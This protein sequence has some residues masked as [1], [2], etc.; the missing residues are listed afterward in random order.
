MMERTDVALLGA[1][2]LADLVASPPDDARSCIVRITS[3]TSDRGP[4]VVATEYD[5]GAPYRLSGDEQV[6]RMV[7]CIGSLSARLA[8]VLIARSGPDNQ[9]RHILPLDP[10]DLNPELETLFSDYSPQGF[11]GF[12]SFVLNATQFI[13]ASTAIHVVVVKLT[14]ELLSKDR[15]ELLRKRL[16]NARQTEIYIAAEA[17]G[18]IANRCVHLP[19]SHFHP[20]PGVTIAVDVPDQNGFGELV[21][22]KNL[23]RSRAITQYRIGDVGRIIPRSCPCTQTEILELQGRKGTDYI[24]VAGAL[25]RR[26]EFDRALALFSEYIDDYQVG[27][28]EILQE[29]FLKGKMVLRVYWRGRAVTPAFCEE[30]SEKISQ[31]IFITPTQTYADAVARGFFLP[32]KVVY[33]SKPFTQG[34]KDIK[35]VLLP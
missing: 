10:Q 14:G 7:V 23:F 27:V 34:H 35:F 2:C 5:L 18:S 9:L 31:N 29:K 4:I 32:L 26:E 33:V 21:I 16:P 3:G 20:M 17:G 28:G 11:H 12:C 15:E 24:K 1:Q 25:L 13:S 30:I 6:E 22:S 8:N 19:R